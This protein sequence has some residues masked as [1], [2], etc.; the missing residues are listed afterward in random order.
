MIGASGPVYTF[1]DGLGVGINPIGSS[2]DLRGFF[3]G[4]YGTRVLDNLME[5]DIDGGGYTNLSTRAI[6][7]DNEAENIIQIA[8]GT[9]DIAQAAKDWVETRTSLS[10]G[11]GAAWEIIMSRA[12]VTTNGFGQLTISMTTAISDDKWTASEIG[13]SSEVAFT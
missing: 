3:L 5:V 1:Q 9:E 11:S 4:S 8:C 6:Y 12:T 13:F 7:S 10:S 2:G